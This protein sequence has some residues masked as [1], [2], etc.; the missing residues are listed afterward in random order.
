[1][2]HLSLEKLIELMEAK[3]RKIVEELGGIGVIA[4]S[5][6][7]DTEKGLIGISDLDLDQR[8]QKYGVNKMER[9]PPPSIFELF[10]DAMKDTTI[11][12]LL[13]AAVISIII[14][15]IS[16]S[17]HLGKTCPRQP[18]W[19]IGYTPGNE[20]HSEG[21]CLEWAEGLAV[22]LACLIVGTITALNN[23]KKE[24]QF[25]A[26][27]AK[28]DD[29]LTTVWRAGNA[30]QVSINDICVGDVVQLDTGSKIPADGIII[31]STDLK[32]DESSLTG[33]SVPVSKNAEEKMFML[34][35][36]AVV[37]GDARYIVTAVGKYSEWGKI[38]TELDT[39]RPDTPLQ[40]KLAGV[41]E[42][43][44][45]FGLAVAV[46]CFLAQTIIWLAD[47]GHKTCFEQDSTGKLTDAEICNEIQANCNASAWKTHYENFHGIQLNN[48]VSQSLGA[49][50]L[51]VIN[52]RT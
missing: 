3:D 18:L 12:V 19:D 48:I 45:K 34:S 35:G 10:L 28:Q 23:Y 8:R 20:K 16:C 46:A 7:S 43:V 4:A 27:Q 15:A 40:I 37:E 21:V 32:V 29:S 26:L 14:G 44:G 52:W 47:M 24:L 5:L 30:C 22:F 33:E 17:I 25:R 49:R 50:F 9:K 41:A 51:F 31:K 2:A 38:M 11:I 1:M 36:C 39:D 13:I 6:G 42:T